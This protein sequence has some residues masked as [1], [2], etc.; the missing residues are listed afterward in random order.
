MQFLKAKPVSKLDDWFI[1]QVGSY[2]PTDQIQFYLATKTNYTEAEFE[3]LI[4]T[5]SEE[6][7]A[8]EVIEARDTITKV[9]KDNKNHSDSITTEWELIIRDVVDNLVAN[10]NFV[11][12]EGNYKTKSNLESSFGAREVFLDK[13]TLIKD[14]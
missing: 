7:F 1:Y 11:V 9:R 6:C 3:K 13:V 4:L 8:N 14:N 12:L 10:H 5:V 2:S